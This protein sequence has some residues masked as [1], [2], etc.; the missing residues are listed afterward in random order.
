M[1]KFALCGTVVIG[2]L[3]LQM[4]IANRISCLCLT[5]R[6]GFRSVSII[7]MIKINNFGPTEMLAFL[8]LWPSFSFSRNFPFAPND[9]R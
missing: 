2:T 9:F 7:G 8:F 4:N 1:V 5:T 3:Q 6:Q